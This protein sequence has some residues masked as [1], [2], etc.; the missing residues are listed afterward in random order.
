MKI[1]N[2]SQKTIGRTK[3]MEFIH[4]TNKSTLDKVKYKGFQTESHYQGFGIFIYPFIKIDFKAPNEEFVLEERD[5]NSNL[6]IEESWEVIGA[7]HIRQAN[8]KV[9]GVIFNLNSEFWPMEINIDVES[10]ISKQFMS[11]FAKLE[12]NDVFYQSN[13]NLTEVVESITVNKYIIEMKFAVFSESGL[14]SLIGCYKKSGGG[15][16]GAFSV[17]CLITKNIEANMIKRIIKF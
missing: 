6:S 7:G 15:I 13:L 4:F 3:G 5:M 12:T 2:K 11:E 10:H 8:E 14:R 16:W 17:Y 9:F 1:K